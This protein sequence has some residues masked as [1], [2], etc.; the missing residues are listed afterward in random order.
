MPYILPLICLFGACGRYGMALRIDGQGM[1]ECDK[2]SFTSLEQEESR[3]VWWAIVILDRFDYLPRLFLRILSSSFHTEYTIALVFSMTEEWLK[4][5][6]TALRFLSIHL[7]SEV[8]LQYPR[9]LQWNV[10]LNGFYRYVKPRQPQTATNNSRSQ[11]RRSLTS[12]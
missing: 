12:R 7:L 4:I 6:R 5:L 8:S 3:R 1:S 11:P 10:L 2:S 9:N